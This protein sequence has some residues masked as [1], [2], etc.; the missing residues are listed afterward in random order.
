M[1]RPP[2]AVGEAVVGHDDDVG[3]GPRRR[4]DVPDRGVHGRVALL[5]RAREIGITGGLGVRRGDVGPEVVLDAVRCVEDDAQQV[6]RIGGQ[7]RPHG[8]RALACLLLEG[9]EI[10]ERARPVV[11]RIDPQ[12]ARRGNLDAVVPELAARPG[13]S[14]TG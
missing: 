11:G 7:Q 3:V 5:D 2:G 13:G 9:G 1:H 4:D 8:G 10:A 14:T 12:V 6:D